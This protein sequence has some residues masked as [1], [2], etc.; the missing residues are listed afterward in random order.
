MQN[1]AILKP[2]KRAYYKKIIRMFGSS[3][4]GFWPLWESNGSVATD[5]S[6]NARHGAYTGVDFGY[7]GIGDGKRSPYFD[8][9]N[10]YV[11]IYSA[12][13]AGAFN[14]AEGTAFIWARVFNAGVWA[15]AAARYLFGLAVDGSNY[16][17]LYRSTVNNTLTFK[18]SAAATVQTIS[19]GSLSSIAWLPCALTWS[20]TN[21]RV[22]AYLVGLQSGGDQTGLAVWAGSLDPATTLIGVVNKTPTSPWYGWLAG[23]FLLNRE[24]TPAEIAKASRLC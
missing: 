10:D 2:G 6:G 8:G 14:S 7:P 3:L 19:I 18:Y 11:D 24:S 12:G 1:P 9:A 16:V 4:I 21:D 20:K 17:R 5:K 23:G 22:R 13:L 15:D